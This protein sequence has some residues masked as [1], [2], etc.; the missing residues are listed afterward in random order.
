MKRMTEDEV[1]QFYEEIGPI[2]F[3][4]ANN[5][6]HKTCNKIGKKKIQVFKQFEEDTEYGQKCINRLLLSYN[7]VVR[8]EA[9]AYC[10]AMNY[11]IQDAVSILEEYSTDTSLGI[12]RLNAEMTLKVWNKNGQLKLY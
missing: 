11:R 7:A 9:A 8:S 1:F 2:L 6:D 12:Y 5:G 4:A 10:L 3:E